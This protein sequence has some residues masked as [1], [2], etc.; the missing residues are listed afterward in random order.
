MG[1]EKYSTNSSTALPPSKY[2]GKNVIYVSNT[3]P[4]NTESKVKDR[5]QKIGYLLKFGIQLIKL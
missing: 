1:L 5:K 4:R 2:T 3:L